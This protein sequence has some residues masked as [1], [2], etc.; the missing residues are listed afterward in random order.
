M[1]KETELDYET[2]EREVEYTVCDVCGDRADEDETA[3]QAVL[4]PRP[5]VTV[6]DNQYGRPVV[7]IR[8]QMVA[9]HK[10]MHH[11][12]KHAPSSAEVQ[13]EVDGRIDICPGCAELLF[14][15]ASP[16]ASDDAD[17]RVREAASSCADA[18]VDEG[19]RMSSLWI[20]ALV[21]IVIMSNILV[22]LGGGGFLVIANAV[23]TAFAAF[24]L[25]WW[26]QA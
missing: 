12:Q 2:V 25:G 13:L 14:D 5:D 24:A 19:R 4:N 18:G 26:W 6:T 10:T 20:G 11:Q 7:T 8:G 9:R 16:S 21:T 17:I 15:V 22:W 23:A 3:S 1:T